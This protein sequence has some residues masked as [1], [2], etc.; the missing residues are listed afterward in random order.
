M[1]G[2]YIWNLIYTLKDVLFILKCSAIKVENWGQHAW[3][4]YVDEFKDCLN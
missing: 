3:P 4:V 1:Q 2:Y